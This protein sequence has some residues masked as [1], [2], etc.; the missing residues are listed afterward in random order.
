MAITRYTHKSDHNSNDGAVV[1]D[2][3]GKA[4]A[5]N[6][7]ILIQ[8]AVVSGQ[9][10]VAIQAPGATDY[11]NLQSTIDLASGPLAY[12]HGIAQRIRFTP[13]GV[14]PGTDYSILMSGLSP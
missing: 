1:V 14:A 7:Q 5:W 9:F 10:T 11:A 8:A 3:N 12:F 6:H 13:V 2:L 4:D